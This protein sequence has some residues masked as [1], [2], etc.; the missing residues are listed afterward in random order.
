MGLVAEIAELRWGYTMADLE[1]LTWTAV[2]RR[3]TSLVLD[4]EDRYETA[5]H[6]IVVALYDSH[7]PPT[8][9]DLIHA[10][11]REV[12]HAADEQ[13]REHGKDMRRSRP[14]TGY[15]KYWLPIKHGQ[16]DGFSDHLVEVMA[17]P[18][19][20][21]VLTA[22]QYE[23]ITALAAH[24]NDGLAA[25]ASLGLTRVAFAQRLSTGRKRVKEVWFEGE[26]VRSGV[27][28]VSGE[29]CRSGHSRAEFGVRVDR[30]PERGGVGWDCTR[31][32]RNKS[33]RRRARSTDL[34][35]AW[36]R[37]LDAELETAEVADVP[38]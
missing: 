35:A 17:L 15:V 5:W 30:G 9:W 19:A 29:A 16:T 32:R 18:A 4:L 11:M 25:A 21:S 24:D 22:A 14:L 2:R 13:L 34:N 38:A 7:E 10:G 3:T 27:S 37:E 23:A 33:R 12:D 1:R 8:R 20:L 28:G 36:Q 26:T 31:C 6:G